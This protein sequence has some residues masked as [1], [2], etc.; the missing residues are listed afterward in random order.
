LANL[1]YA[2]AMRNVETNCNSPKKKATLRC[3]TTFVSMKPRP[4]ADSTT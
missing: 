1:E 3:P 4:K 2:Q